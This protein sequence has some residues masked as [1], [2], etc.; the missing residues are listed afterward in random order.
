MSQLQQVAT[1]AEQYKQ[2][3]ETGQLS[4][5]EFKELI[6]DLNIMGHIEQGADELHQNE[7]YYKILMGVVQL[8]SLLPV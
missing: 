1:L 5:S 2:Q 7:E 4:A 6:E 8:A 3:Y